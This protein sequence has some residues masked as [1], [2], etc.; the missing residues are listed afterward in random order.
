MMLMLS[1][2]QAGRACERSVSGR[3]AAHRSSLLLWHPLSAPLPLRGPPAPAPL[4]LT[5]FSAR[6]AHAPL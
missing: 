3:F 2:L 5:W 6:S 4:P 1:L